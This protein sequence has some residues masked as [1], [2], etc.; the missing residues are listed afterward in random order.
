[1]PTEVRISFLAVDDEPL[2]EV[3]NNSD[4]MTSRFWDEPTPD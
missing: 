4:L 3:N 2:Q 1:M